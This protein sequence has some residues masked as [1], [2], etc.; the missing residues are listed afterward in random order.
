MQARA[1]TTRRGTEAA[2]TTSG[3][4]I[5]DYPSAYMPGDRRRALA[6]GEKLPSRVMGA[7]LFA[8][9]SGFTALTEALANE[10]GSQRASEVLTGHLNRVFHAVIS[11]LD[12][13]G[14]EVIYFSGDAITCWLNGDDGTRATASG[15]A[16]QGA[17]DRESEVR[18]PAGLAFQLALKVAVVTGHARRF[19]VGDPA[20]QLIDV[21]AG[22]LIDRLTATEQLAEAGEV[23]VGRDV[24]AALSGSAE[25]GER[26]RSEAAGPVTVVTRLHREIPDVPLTEDDSA[27]LPEAI[28]RQWLLPAVYERLSTGRGQ[29]LAE[30]RP[31]YPMF[32]SFSGIRYDGDA[33]GCQE[34]DAFVRAAQQVLSGYG[35]NVLQLTLGDKGAYLYG[36]FGTPHAHED[37][38]D[39]VCAAALE[40]QALEQT[41][42]A[43]EIRVGIAHGRLWSGTYGHARRRTF[44]CLGDAVNLAARLMS[45]APAGEIY[46]SELVRRRTAERFKW[47]A[48][49]PLK[50]KGKASPVGAHSLAGASTQHTRRVVR[51]RQPIVGRSSELAALERALVDSAA[52]RGQ[53]IGISAEAGM[54]KSRLLAEF[55][56]NTRGAGITV[57]FGECQAFGTST[58]YY[59]WR[60]IWRSLL[61]IPDGAPDSEQIAA[62]ERSLRAIDPAFVQ[63][64]PL[65]DVVLGI[66]IPDNSLTSSFDPKL[67]KTSL[68]NLLGDC[69]RARAAAEPLVLVLEDCHWL[70]PL[71]REL[72]DV[73][74]R[75]ATTAAVLIVC[76]YR[77]DASLPAGLAL[78]ALH[79]LQ[80]LPLAAL[81]KEDMAAAV[82]EKLAALI[83]E[84]PTDA[85]GPLIDL[86]VTRAQG[87]PL[88]AEELLNFIHA[89]GI[90]RGDEIRVR[91]FELPDS[92]HSLILS[93]IDT[94]QESSRRTLKLASVVGRVFRAPTLPI[95]YRDLVTLD[96]VRSDL[97][98][99]LLLDLVI[100]DREEDESRLFKHAMTQAV[101]YESLPYG[102]RATLH[103]HV[104]RFLEASGPDAIERNLDLLAHHYWHSDDAAKKQLY[105]GRAA[106]AAKAAYANAAAIDYYERLAPLLAESERI[107]ALLELGAVLEIVGVWD[108]AHSTEMTALGLAE[109]ISNDRAR[110][111]CETALADVAWKQARYEE[112]DERLAR[113]G[114]TFEAVGD[115]PGLGR[116]AHI[117]GT[118]AAQRGDLVRARRSY[119]HSLA[120]RRRLGDR[121][122]MAS[123]LSNLGIVAE[124]E[125]DYDLARSLH[126]QSLALR[127]EL[128]DRW[129]IANSI[130]NL[131]MIALLEGQCGKARERFEEAM[132]LYREVGDS[133][134][135]ALS[136]NN[137]GNATR[138]LGDLATAAE[139]YGAS[140]RAY[141]EYGDK[142]AL[143]FLLEDVG[144]FGALLGQA[145]GALELVGAADRLREEIGAPRAESLE[146]EIAKAV[147]PAIARLDAD[148]RAAIRARG[149]MLDLAA[150]VD[151]ALSLAVAEDQ[152]K[153]M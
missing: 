128:G 88:Y 145:E 62:L 66:T 102:L 132:R 105:L 23:V 18:T 79:G 26:R 30:L 8:D 51:Y 129:A 108:R 140:L 142:W 15:L 139:H 13:F 6:A 21:L 20:I 73:I 82:R 72:L 99:L 36:V 122:M 41:T 40:L 118:L 92:L 49:E 54:G 96:G 75:T 144:R 2:A 143:A 111:R 42:A 48:L 87:N 53:T 150:A 91:S 68:E 148:E 3:L 37:D 57:A 101:V 123:V 94:L 104:G 124:Y 55:V 106:E 103:G 32:V 95:I 138:D 80:E 78:G 146:A 28:A 19:V 5:S 9:I 76:A 12:R 109:E 107:D 63:R 70:D 71:S 31:A 141:R 47:K 152:D 135:V 44:V 125:A 113:A 85:D 56:R 133:R 27:G 110:A 33:A 35:G 16:M 22:A 69:L 84:E 83:E 1:A 52:G 86:V 149:R 59:V 147:A 77:P 98:T 90:G 97:E 137:L 60:E 89:S 116:V 127:C 4:A 151:A 117:E 58:S 17:M 131:G 61:A 43:R 134:S 112:A 100:P 114:A 34:L 25:F 45:K 64:A 46:A 38:A 93:R 81:A 130:T 50:L 14:G 29:F 121:P 67:R 65:L 153:Q 119:E 74:A 10:L 136:D 115:D 126:E 24:A 120:I 7:S 11:E 39:R